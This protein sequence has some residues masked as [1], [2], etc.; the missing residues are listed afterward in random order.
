MKPKDNQL[1][2]IFC[3]QVLVRIRIIA[4]RLDPGLRQPLPDGEPATQEAPVERQPPRD[5]LHR[6]SLHPNMALTNGGNLPRS[7]RRG[8]SSPRLPRPSSVES[9]AAA[10]PRR[11]E[12]DSHPNLIL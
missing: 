1:S 7:T 8:H 10:H 6:D 12:A 4:Q 3:R 9:Q 11:L 5:S 2:S